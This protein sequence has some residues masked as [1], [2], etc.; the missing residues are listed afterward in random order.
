[1]PKKKW[2]SFIACVLM[3]MIITAGLVKS[4]AINN[5]P[6]LFIDPKIPYAETWKEA[7]NI[8]MQHPFKGIGV[9]LFACP[10]LKAT[11]SLIRVHN[12]YLDILMS[13]G[14]F[15]L[16]VFCALVFVSLKTILKNIPS[17]PTRALR[18]GVGGGL[19]VFLIMNLFN[20]SLMR[21]ET[22][23]LFW[24]LMGLGVKAALI[25]KND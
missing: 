11:I 23:A 6:A 14:I 3:T 19:I 21:H 18:I 1:M 16:A 5:L 9:D 17:A 22:I 15:G 4:A 24:V 20:D 10:F 25:D 2:G 8:F 12:Q 7:L 13:V